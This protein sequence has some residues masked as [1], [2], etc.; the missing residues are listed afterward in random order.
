MPLLFGEGLPHV[1]V[2]CYVASDSNVLCVLCRHAVSDMAWTPDGMTILACSGDGTIALLMFSEKELGGPL[3][4]VRQI[5]RHVL[6]NHCPGPSP[7]VASMHTWSVDVTWFQPFCWLA[8]KPVLGP[9]IK[10]VCRHLVCGIMHSRHGRQCVAC[11]RTART[12]TPFQFCRRRWTSTFK[13]CMAPRIRS[14]CC[15][16]RAR[17]SCAWKLLRRKGRELAA[18]QLPRPFP[19]PCPGPG[20]GSLP[21]GW[22]PGWHRP[23]ALRSPEWRSSSSP[24]ETFIRSVRIRTKHNDHS[25]QRPCVLA[26]ISVVLTRSPSVRAPACAATSL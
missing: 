1:W 12:R 7:Q 2:R 4:Q 20:P 9:W 19:C 11:M 6:R 5:W 15:L 22:L 23:M 10:P 16:R 18:W 8:W 14:R 17:A 25:S 13:A 21:A 3:S 26:L 24:G